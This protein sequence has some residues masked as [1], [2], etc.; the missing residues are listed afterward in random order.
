VAKNVGAGVLQRIK[1]LSKER[2]IDVQVLVRR[3][4]QER[5]VYRLSVSEEAKNFCLK[6]GLLLS[7]YNGGDLLRPTED[8][9]FN[10]FDGRGDVA[11]L[12]KSLKAALSTPVE[13]DGV[14]FHLESMKIQ[15]DRVGIVPGGKV[16]LLA[17]V[18]TA[19]AE[20]RVDVG[21][22]NPVTPN[23]EMMTIPTL[24]DN[25]VPQ[26]VIAAYPLETVVA[27][28]LHAMV[29]FGLFNTRIKDYY[30]VWMLLRLHPFSGEQLTAAI[31]KTFEHQQRTIPDVIDGLS[32]TFAAK[33]EAAWSKF[34]RQVA[35]ETTTTLAEVV[36]EIGDFL[37]PVL[38]KVRGMDAEPGEWTPSV[39]WG[40]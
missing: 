36:T 25:M 35:P 18:G 1:N 15:K 20:V 3:Y 31:Q 10:G 26:P 40:S 6:G 23:A 4:A 7:V 24:L 28:K 29:Q 8:V 37:A 5:L 2:G 17:F 11:T 38:D 22:G 39:G 30:D 34:I 16:S 21:F 19:R 33:N 27:E 14:V 12:E 13:D 32:D 9:D